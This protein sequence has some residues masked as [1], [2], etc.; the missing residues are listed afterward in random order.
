MKSLNLDNMKQVLEQL[1]QHHSLSKA[2]AKQVFLNMAKG[3]Y[4]PSQIAAF[5]A[6]YK[7]RNVEVEELLGF[8]E[9]LLELSIPIDLS[10]FGAMDLCGTGGDSKNTFNISTLSAFVAAG[11]GVKVAKHGNYGVS[12][13]CGSSNVLEYLGYRFTNKPDSLKKQMEEANICVLHA[14]LFHPALKVV[15]PIRKG[16]GMSSIF[17]L[18]GPMVNPSQPKHQL[19]G[20]FHQEVMRLYQYVYQQLDVEYILVHSLDGYDEVSLTGDV[21]VVSK[22]EDSYFSPQK[23][24]FSKLEEVDLFGGNS[25]E[26]AAKI[27]INVLG[28]HATK[29]QKEVVL[30]NATWAIQ[31][32]RPELDYEACRAFAQKSLESGAALN[33]FQKLISLNK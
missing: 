32:S 2:E 25:I 13:I 22:G 15:G 5:L 14:P 29:A 21:R 20:V 12:S 18:L 27:F 11:A 30:A 19:I 31:C 6:V 9:A 26:E 16:F 23:L 28:N 1:F 24:G 3:I 4:E 7:M 33:K 8:R 17:N 10:E